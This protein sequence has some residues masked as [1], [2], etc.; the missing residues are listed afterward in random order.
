V[1][2]N[3]EKIITTILSRT[4]LIRIRSFSDEEIKDQLMK[5]FSIEEKRAG[6]LAHLAE[7][8]MNEALRLKDEI[9][10]DNHQLFRDWMRSCYKKNNIPEMVGWSESFQKIGREAQ[11]HLLQYG[12]NTIRETFLFRHTGTD[13]VRLHEDELK[14]VEGFSKVLD[15]LKIEHISRHL[16][17]AYYHIERNANPKILFLDLSLHISSLMKK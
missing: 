2:N 10:E 15:D 11:K 16:N 9:Q 12:L 13:I 6:Q 17:E 5:K 4:Q 14:F 7:G 1:T 3:S 8:N